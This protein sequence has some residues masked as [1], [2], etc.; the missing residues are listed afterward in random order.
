MWIKRTAIWLLASIAFAGAADRVV[1][2]P[3][4][5]NLHYQVPSPT[6]ENGPA[7]FSDDVPGPRNSLSPFHPVGFEP[8]FDWF[9]PA[10]TSG[11]GRG[12]RP[13]IGYFFSYERLFWSLSSPERAPVGS[14][15]ADPFFLGAFFSNGPTVDNSWIGATGAWG[16]RWEVGYTDTDDY[17]WLVSVLDHVS[18]GQYCIADNP[19]ILFGDPGFL[20]TGVVSVQIPDT[21][22]AEFIGVLVGLPYIFSEI[23][24]QNLL[25]LNGVELMRF[26]RA[27]QLHSGAYFELLY[28]ARW[29]QIDDAFIVDATGNG[30]GSETASIS[31]GGPATTY[32][33]PTNILDGSTWTNRVFNNLVGPQI[34]GRL[35]VE[36]G[37][38]VTSLE[39][40]FLAAANFQ[41]VQ[42]K[43]NLG[44]QTII[45]QGAINSNIA[46]IFRG[47]G[48]KTNRYDTTF[49]P[50]GELRVNVTWQATRNV[51]LKIGYTGMVVGNISRASNRINYD[52]VNLIG[53]SPSR[54]HQ[55]FFV[56]GLNFGVEINR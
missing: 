51:G 3:A 43:T 42:L 21:D 30:T 34:G 15:T 10:E 19:A 14:E 24:M 54:F 41:N 56:N 1:A 29:F 18:Q 11:Y 17:G 47:L 45:N 20:L 32:T 48:S 37:R 8:Q 49:A 23:T 9:A 22:P 52:D 5:S 7:A 27:R 4:H 26:Y 16:N 12:P 31:I 35:F 39:A 40:R 46:T 55:L 25:R 28:G 13:H 53:I 33:F 38:W 50:M 2:Q 6:Y 36:R 44:D